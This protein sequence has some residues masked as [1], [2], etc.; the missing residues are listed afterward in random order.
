MPEKNDRINKQPDW[1]KV[2]KNY[3]EWVPKIRILPTVFYDVVAIICFVV[4]IIIY[5]QAFSG[6]L[7]YIGILSIVC[8]RC[9]CVTA[10]RAGHKEGYTDGYRDGYEQGRDDCIGLTEDDRHFIDIESKIP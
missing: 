8:V 4:A 9:L 6:R 7:I 3:K 2:L 1:D 10:E 5:N